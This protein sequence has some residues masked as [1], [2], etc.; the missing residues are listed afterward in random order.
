[1]SVLLFSLRALVVLDYGTV[2]FI[3]TDV[4]SFH[5]FICLKSVTLIN[6]VTY[7]HKLK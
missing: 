7:F 1:M 3:I 5:L 2:F 4:T 6:D